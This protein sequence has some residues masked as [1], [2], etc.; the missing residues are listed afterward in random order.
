MH[1]L[2]LPGLD[3][4]AALS[5]PFRRHL[6]DDYTCDVAEYSNTEFEGYKAIEARVRARIRDRGAP[7][8][9]VAESFSGPVAIRLAADPEPNLAALVLVSTFVLPPV[10]SW[11]RYFVVSAMFLIPLPAFVIR[12]LLVGA[13]AADALVADVRRAIDAP[14]ATV[15]AHRVREVLRVDVRD[16]LSEITLPMLCLTSTR[17]RLLKPVDLEL[18]RGEVQHESIDAPHLLL[19]TYPREAA[20]SILDFVARLGG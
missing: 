9:L 14:A 20:A 16:A 1:V 7:V 3:G 12:R 4:G 13:D 5:L 10:P 11:L 8:V 6:P 17:D 18:V 19:Q 15:L 2:F